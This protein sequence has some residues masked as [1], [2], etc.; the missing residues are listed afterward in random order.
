[1]PE[2]INEEQLARLIDEV[3]TLTAP[4]GLGD[5]M[6]DAT[7]LFLPGFTA[8][9]A[10]TI[11]SN[12]SWKTRI[13]PQPERWR[14][15]DIMALKAVTGTQADPKIQN[16]FFT[17][18]GDVEIPLIDF[19][20]GRDVAR[21]E[22]SIQLKPK[23]RW[24]T[25]E[26]QFAFL[27]W[28]TERESR[29]WTSKDL[30]GISRAL[31]WGAKQLKVSIELEGQHVPLE[32]R[33]GVP[34]WVAKA[35]LDGIRFPINYAAKIVSPFIFR[36]TLDTSQRLPSGRVVDLMKES[37]VLQFEFPED[38]LRRM[39]REAG[40]GDPDL[41][42]I[43]IF[44]NALP[45]MN[46]DLKAWLLNDSYAEFVKASG[47]KPLGTAGI[48]PYLKAG[49][50]P[51]ED[52]EPLN[53]NANVISLEIEK[54]GQV[55]S[56]YSLPGEKDTVATKQLL[57]WMTHGPP[58]NGVN[59]KYGGA[60]IIQPLQKPSLLL[61][62]TFTVLPCFGGYDCGETRDTDWYQKLMM[63]Y[64]TPP[65]SLLYRDSLIHTISELVKKFGYERVTVEGPETE[66]RVIGGV[67]R[68]VTVAYVNNR[69]GRRIDPQH[70]AVIQSFVE[71]RAPIG[72]LF[73]LELR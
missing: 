17:P 39:Y 22:K 40:L 1:M 65:Q 46:V 11:L 60:D 57:L 37:L 48:Y 66:L 14:T 69:G 59:Y 73:L 58:I 15:G 63:S 30:L 8:L 45:V 24:E 49:K 61:N 62:Q 68:R 21:F 28:D 12:K 5:L 47:M 67:R 6:Q 19:T 7:G 2:S 54:D 10:V 26:L 33:W 42:G 34:P 20:P 9:P 18:V 70:I 64:S 36:I 16:V 55:L 27:P 51:K 53:A 41:S 23:D 71:D 3:R 56:N 4:S 32:P 43:S 35:S 44:G 13:K 31:D 72:A 52:L 25:V 38:A 50:V 29:E